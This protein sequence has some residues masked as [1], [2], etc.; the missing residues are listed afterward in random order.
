LILVSVK[1]DYTTNCEELVTFNVVMAGW[2]AYYY[3]FLVLVW[4]NLV[5]HVLYC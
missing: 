1:G 4:K 2:H 5:I 3:L